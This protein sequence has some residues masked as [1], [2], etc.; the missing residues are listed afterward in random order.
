VGTHRTLVDDRAIL[1]LRH[2]DCQ[3]PEYVP[4]PSDLI[5][6]DKNKEYHLHKC[7]FYRCV[8]EPGA[9]IS[10][11]NDRNRVQNDK[12]DEHEITI[13]DACQV[14]S[15]LINTEICFTAVIQQVRWLGSP[16]SFDTGT[17]NGFE[18]ECQGPGG[19]SC[20]Q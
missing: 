8:P 9:N 20:F 19:D 18:V 1:A 3:R 16:T 5:F 13:V 7:F 4:G 15:C 14:I 17:Q 10:S 11:P 12:C 2:L 6:Q